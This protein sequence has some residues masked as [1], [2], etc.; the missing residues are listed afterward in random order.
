M[1]KHRNITAQDLE[2]RI[3]ALEDVKLQSFYQDI[4]KMALQEL[5]DGYQERYKSLIGHHFHYHSRVKER[6]ND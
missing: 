3:T 2:K 1:R 6:K 4:D 5:I